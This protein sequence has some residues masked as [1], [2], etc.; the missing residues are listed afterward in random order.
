VPIV[1]KSVALNLLESSGPVQ[2]CN[3]IALPL[4]L[5]LLELIFIP[6]VTLKDAIEILNAASSL[7]VYD[8]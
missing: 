6:D 1:L 3:G 4:L 2:S 5:L 8:I 7:T